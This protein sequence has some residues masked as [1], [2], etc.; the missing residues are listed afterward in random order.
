MRLSAD[1]RGAILY[2]NPQSEKYGGKRESTWES[3]RAT[4]KRTIR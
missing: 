4:G 2:P 3:M 1:G